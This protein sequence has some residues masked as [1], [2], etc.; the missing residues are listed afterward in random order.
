MI[1][2]SPIPNQIGQAYLW[3]HFDFSREQTIEKTGSHIVSVLNL[4][5]NKIG[6]SQTVSSSRPQTGI[7]THNG[8][9]V[10]SFD[11]TRF[12]NFADNTLETFLLLYL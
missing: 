12:L 2:R 5:G 9:N 4:S 11:G 3:S 6:L 10:A 1:L 7:E 8:L